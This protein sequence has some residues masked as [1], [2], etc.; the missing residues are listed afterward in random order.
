MTTSFRNNGFARERA[1][2]VHA[3]RLAD[4]QRGLGLE[5]QS[6]DSDARLWLRDTSILLAS[7]ISPFFGGSPSRTPRSSL[8][9]ELGGGLGTEVGS[10]CGAFVEASDCTPTHG[11]YL[12]CTAMLVRWLRGG[13][14]QCTTREYHG[15]SNTSPPGA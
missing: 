8:E 14:T 11:D 2:L 1:L 6:T 15:V 7:C 3:V 10:A 13:R 5:A 4:C 9:R 12:N